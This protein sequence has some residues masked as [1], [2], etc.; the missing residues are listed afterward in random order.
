MK[1]SAAERLSDIHEYYFSKKLEQI[2]VMNAQGRKV[3]NLGIGSPDLPPSAETIAALAD[4]AARV[5]SHGY[6]SYRGI[7]ELREAL[8]AWYQSTYGVTLNPAS[9]VLPLLGSKEGLFYISMAFLNPGDQVLVPNPGYPAYSA[10]TKLAGADVVA[11]DLVEAFGWQPD[12]AALEKRDLSKVKLM[13]VNYPNMPTGQRASPALF[14][15]LIEFGRKHGIFICHDNPYSLVLNSEKPMSLLSFDPEMSCSL[16]LNS[17]SKAFNMAGWRVGTVMASAAV[18]DAVLRVKSNV[19]SGMFLPV[20][21]AA[22]VA[23]QNSTAWHDERNEIYRRRQKLATQIFDRLGFTV[24]P[25]QEGLFVWAKAPG[26]VANVEAR[27]DEIL[28]RCAVF[29]TPGFIFGTNGE[30]FA[31]CS[32]CLPENKYAEALE[33]LEKL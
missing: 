29:L 33:R 27:M 25:Q 21:K 10:V 5:D 7:P 14:T 22:I 11:Y 32:L 26:T 17:F 15:K 24:R 16:E 19:D 2:R 8:A 12:F 18:I 13:W 23:L 20:Q 6:A 3:L 4:S 1:L 30:R 9:E 31:R 28:T